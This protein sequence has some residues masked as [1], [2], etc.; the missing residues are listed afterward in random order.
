[1]F[2]HTYYHGVIK[3][4]VALFGT[5]FNDVYVNRYEA[6]SGMTTTVK[7]PISYGPKE[8][9]LVRALGDPDL[10]RQP[11]IQLPRMSFEITSMEYATNRKL[12]TVGKRAIK[13]PTNAN[14]LIYQYN[15][16]PY[17]ISFTLSIMVKNA[18]DG[19]NIVEQ[20]LPFFTPEWTTTVELIPEM[21]YKVDIPVVLTSVSVNDD[22]E[23][24]FVTRRAII[25]TLEFTMKAY[26]FGPTRKGQIIKFANSNIFSTLTTPN[27]YLSAVDVRPGLLANGQPTT[28]SEATVSITDIEADDNFGYIVT[29]ENPNA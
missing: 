6:M 21:D 28:N 26:V 29:V 1:M 12:N 16:V 5:L 11:A 25:W 22:Y 13:D 14:R 27:T 24:D 10:N 18:D 20:I 17:D 19:A 7:V 4:Y 15:P 9:V 23:N 2:G 3:K 8:K